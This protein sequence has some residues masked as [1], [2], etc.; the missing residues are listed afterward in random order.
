MTAPTMGLGAALFRPFWASSMQRRIY[1][2]SSIGVLRF[3]YSYFCKS[4]IRNNESNHRLHPPVIA[5]T[6]SAGRAARS[7]DADLLR[8]A[9]SE[10]DRKSTRLNSSHANIS[11][12][13]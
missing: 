10:R 8:Y 12:A 1:F 5:G 13:V 7:F 9:G 3:I 4:N 11:Y 2:S 6:L